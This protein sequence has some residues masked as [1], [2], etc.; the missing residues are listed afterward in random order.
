MEYDIEQIVQEQPTND[1]K[2]YYIKWQGYDESQNTWE[3]N[4]NPVETQ[5]LEEWENH[6]TVIN[7]VYTARA[8]T[9]DAKS[10]LHTDPQNLKDALSKLDCYLWIN[11]MT[12]K[13]WSL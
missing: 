6:N 13:I 11:M 8:E 10:Y 2:E 9:N 3:P 1:R 12:D 7:I 4:E 5:A